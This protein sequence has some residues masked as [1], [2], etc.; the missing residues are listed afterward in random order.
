VLSQLHYLLL[1][2]ASDSM[3]N[4]QCY[5]WDRRF[6]FYFYSSLFAAFL[7]SGFLLFLIIEIPSWLRAR[8]L[9]RIFVSSLPF[10]LAVTPFLLWCLY[11]DQLPPQFEGYATCAVGTF[12]TEGVMFGLGSHGS[13]LTEPG[14][15]LLAGLG[16][17]LLYVVLAWIIIW[18]IGR[19]A[20]WALRPTR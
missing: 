6:V 18:S 15:L 7:L 11:P 16:S 8:A 4:I 2:Q 19:R 14:I 9:A 5:D 1:R 12:A 13:V 10:L 17:W 20:G 3:Q